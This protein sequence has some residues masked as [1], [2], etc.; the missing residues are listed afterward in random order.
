MNNYLKDNRVLSPHQLSFQSA[1]S[2]VSQLAYLYHVF[3]EP[4][5]AKQM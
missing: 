5:D 2:T 3:S 4:L 1:D